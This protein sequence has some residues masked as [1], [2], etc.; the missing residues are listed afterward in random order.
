MQGHLSHFIADNGHNFQPKAGNSIFQ[1]ASEYSAIILLVCNLLRDLFQMNNSHALLVPNAA[2]YNDTI[3]DIPEDEL[4]QEFL[5]WRKSANV[6]TLQLCHYPFLMSLACKRR[7][8]T[9]LVQVEQSRAQ[10]A[11]AHL[12]LG[13][14]LFPLECDI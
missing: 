1:S 2:F 14:V 4:V 3:S 8:L 10:Q 6:T 7:L 12:A 9:A 11:A 13:L 5:T